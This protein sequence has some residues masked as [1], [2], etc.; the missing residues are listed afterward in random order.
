MA[1]MHRAQAVGLGEQGSPSGVTGLLD[2]PLDA[3]LERLVI[4]APACGREDR[5]R[6]DHR[7]IDEVPGVAGAPYR[8]VARLAL[9]KPVHRGE[10]VAPGDL[11]RGRLGL[12]ELL[13][14]GLFPRGS[15]PPGRR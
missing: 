3:L 9:A 2:D 5:D 13:S 8:V 4:D 10:E 15:A 14:E 7:Q 12:D 1:A 6:A 11:G